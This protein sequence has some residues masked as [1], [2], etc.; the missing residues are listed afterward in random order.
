[1]PFSN[2]TLTQ[3]FAGCSV[4]NGALT[5]PSGTI[6]SFVPVSTSSGVQ[7]LVFGLVDTLAGVVSANTPSNITV[8]ESSSLPSDNVLR[9][10]YTF[11]VNL[12]YDSNSVE[13]ILNV[14]PEPVV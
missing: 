2:D 6:R 9:K 14:S 8:T 12:S 13:S 3:I 4:S 11:S 10:T 1:M 5:I 7:E